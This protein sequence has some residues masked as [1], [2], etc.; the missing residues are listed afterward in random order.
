MSWWLWLILLSIFMVVSKETDARR[1]I[2]NPQCSLSVEEVGVTAV[3][4][5]GLRANCQLRTLRSEFL[6]PR[7]HGRN[8]TLSAVNHSLHVTSLNL[9]CSRQV[10]FESDLQPAAFSAFPR[11]QE[12]TLNSCKLKELPSRTF[13]GLLQLKRLTINT[14]HQDWPGASL[15]IDSEA[16][17]ELPRLER[18]DLSS[19]ELWHVPVG[20]LCHLTSLNTVNL[21]R[22][23]LHRFSDL[24]LEANCEA[25]IANLLLSYNELDEFP[26][27]SLPT[28]HLDSLHLDYNRLARIDD[29]ALK[30]LTEIKELILSYNKLVALPVTSFSDLY[31][32]RNLDIANNSLSS[33]PP[34]IFK[35]L[36]QL[37]ALNISN[38]QLTLSN[39]NPDPF[40]GLIRLVVLDISFNRLTYLGSH[41]FDHLFSLQALFLTNN[42]ISHLNEGVFSNL[43]NLYTLDLSNNMM[44]TLES[45]TLKGLSVLTHLFI[46]NND[47][48][49]V[50]DSSFHNCSSLE[51][52]SLTNNRIREIPKAITSLSL[53]HELDLSHN[54][55]DSL[56]GSNL[57]GLNNLKSLSLS[58][59]MLGNISIDALPRLERLQYLD[60]SHNQIGGVEREAFETLTELVSLNMSHNFLPDINGL[61][62]HLPKLKF[63]NVS[64]NRIAWF[65]YALIPRSLLELD[66]SYNMVKVIDNYYEIHDKLKLK[67]VLARNNNISE[68]SQSSIPNGIEI[69]D[70]SNNLIDFVSSNTFLLKDRVN[71]IH[72]EGNLLN[73]LEES[74]LRLPPRSSVASSASPPTLFLSDNPLKC[75]CG[76]EW[77]S[78]A[79]HEAAGDNKVIPQQQHQPQ[80]TLLPRLGSIADVKCSLPG[81]WQ[82]VLVPLVSVHQHQFLCTYRRHCFTLCHC[83]DFDAC[84]C[85]QTCPDSCSCYHDHTW[86]HNIVDCGC[87]NWTAMPLGVPMDVTEAFVDGN[88]MGNLTSHALIGRKNL[89]VLYLNNSNIIDIQNRTFNG[90]RNL[91]VLRLNNNYLKA[92]HGFEFVLLH[93]LLELHLDNNQISYVSNTTFTSLR[94]LEVLRLEHNKISVFPVWNLALN[95]FLVEVSLYQNHWSCECNFLANLKAWLEGNR[96][97]ATNVNEISCYHNKTGR[98]G[99]PILSNAPGH[100]DHYVSTTHINSLI[101]QDYI[102]FV[103]ISLALLFVLVVFILL[104]VGYRRRLK[105]WAAGQYSRHLFE[106]STAYIEEREKLFDVFIS[107]SNTD[108]SWVYGVLTPE[109]EARGYR[110]CAAYRNCSSPTAP[111]VAQAVSEGIACSQRLIVVVSRDLVEGEWCKYD[112]KSTHVEAIKK[113]S[114]KQIILINLEDIPKSELDSEMIGIVKKSNFN[115]KPRDPRFWERLKSA[116]PSLRNRRLYEEGQSKTISSPLVP[117]DVPL[118]DPTKYSYPPIRNLTLNPYWETAIISNLPE[119]TMKKPDLGAPPWV[120]ATP[121]KNISQSPAISSPR[122]IEVDHTYMSVSE[123]DEPSNII[124][125]NNVTSSAAASSSGDGEAP[126]QDSKSNNKL[127]DNSQNGNVKSFLPSQTSPP[128]LSLHHQHM[129]Q[130]RVI[131]YQEAPQYQ[132]PHHTLHHSQNIHH[133][134]TSH[135]SPTTHNSKTLLHSNR[136]SPPNYSRPPSSNYSNPAVNLTSV[137]SN[138]VT[139][140]GKKLNNITNANHDGLENVRSRADESSPSEQQLIDE[141]TYDCR[142]AWIY[143]TPVNL[144]ST[145][146]GQTYYV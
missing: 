104:A 24:G 77:L 120:A 97:K 4:R 14:R 124:L 141:E 108:S 10:V 82:D 84:D 88:N 72:L 134:A 68:I 41:T 64:N 60:L 109:L 13:A 18:L 75:D 136:P 30:N 143:Q 59:N 28:P 125:L 116:L 32:L 17:T 3:S 57:M 113:M 112:F 94:A 11:L 81:L 31:Q 42:E 98:P 111:I 91:Q 56:Q 142:N 58:H 61:A 133:N 129:V 73:L 7:H 23:R 93:N 46:N 16:L 29:E 43:A 121:L 67:N 135:S 37:L 36:G 123:C 132:I 114:K 139:S 119:D 76:A 27:K 70:F 25:P 74:S 126:K 83:C 50:S 63:L 99:P 48:Q 51:K 105:M 130:N 144:P 102:M 1:N 22:N 92:L 78:R 140:N 39:E 53:L 54:E 110:T 69:L 66:F 26:S 146:C 122:P 65:D 107:H 8:N 62:L 55:I 33:L 106:K 71:E 117:Q 34:N 127:T 40:T 131:H 86:T 80:I 6:Q 118:P 20:A 95:P 103:S 21:T 2:A 35:S 9:F 38:N 15:S 44:T 85:E 137:A 49:K 145:N 5:E 45:E 128:L 79:A 87:Q 115:L 138:S 96:I 19:S 100:C 90:L 12:L 89:R 101:V 52:L 47:I